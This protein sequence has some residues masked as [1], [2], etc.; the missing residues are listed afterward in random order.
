[1]KFYFDIYLRAQGAQVEMPLAFDE[2][3]ELSGWTRLQYVDAGA[4]FSLTGLPHELGDGTEL[5]DGEEAELAAGTLWVTK[6]AW[7]TLR[8]EIHN[9]KCDVLLFDHAANTV[10]GLVYGMQ[11]N[12]SMLL[13]S[14]ESA[15]ISLQG[16]RGM[17]NEGA[18]TLLV[19]EENVES[20]NLVMVDDETAFMMAPGVALSWR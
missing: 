18:G 10:V 19:M 12:V 11:M 16:K 17:G 5:T 20:L 13:V 7:E 14:G 1:M 9:K 2:E 15:L 3:L 8:S 4:K 6:D